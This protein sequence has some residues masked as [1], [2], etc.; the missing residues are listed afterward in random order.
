MDG[1]MDGWMQ[2]LCHH[3]TE[4]GTAHPVYSFPPCRVNTT[5]WCVSAGGGREGETSAESEVE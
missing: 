3:A 1:W 5:F 4:E 2:H